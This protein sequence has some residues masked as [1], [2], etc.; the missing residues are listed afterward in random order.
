MFRCKLILYNF[1]E[2]GGHRIKFMKP[3]LKYVFMVHLFGILSSQS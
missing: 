2:I 1:N 3:K